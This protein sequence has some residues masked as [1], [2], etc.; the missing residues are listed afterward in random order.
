M[1]ELD[2]Q[3]TQAT[4]IPEEDNSPVGDLAVYKYYAS[5]LGWFRIGLFLVFLCGNS[6]FGVMT[7]EKAPNRVLYLLITDKHRYLAEQMG[8]E[9]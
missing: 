2:R 5:A 7:C 8:F 4:E 6:G 3:L 1:S 9:R